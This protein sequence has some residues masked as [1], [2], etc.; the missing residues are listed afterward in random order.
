M[1]NISKQIQKEESLIQVEESIASVNE[2]FRLQNAEE[3]QR[4]EKKYLP[5]TTNLITAGY[6]VILYVKHK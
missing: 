5:S 2:I 1:Q 3:L 6:G 4:A